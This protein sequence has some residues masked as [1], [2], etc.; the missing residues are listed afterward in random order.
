MIYDTK[1]VQVVKEKA[2]TELLSIRVDLK[3]I[4]MIQIPDN[5]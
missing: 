5:E 4:K 1:T 3:I 2:L